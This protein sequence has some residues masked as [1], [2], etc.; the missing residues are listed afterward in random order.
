M[1]R[2]IEAIEYKISRTVNR[3]VICPICKYDLNHCQCRYG[4]SAHPDRSKRLTVVIDHLYLLSKR[5]VK[6]IIALEKFWQM[7][8]M[9]CEREDI[10]R[11]LERGSE[12]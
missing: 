5:Q 1:R 12:R 3:K 6:H 2:L 11:E 10:R 9:D 7:S 4:G 8:Y